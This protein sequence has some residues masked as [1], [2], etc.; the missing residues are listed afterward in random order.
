MCSSKTAA[1]VEKKKKKEA[2]YQQEKTRHASYVYECRA[3]P[4]LHFLCKAGTV[5]GCGKLQLFIK[6]DPMCV[7]AETSFCNVSEN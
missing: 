5:E 3:I 4:T 2:D 6:K 7:G 1:V